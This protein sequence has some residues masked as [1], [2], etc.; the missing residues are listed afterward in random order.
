MILFTLK[1]LNPLF[2]VRNILKIVLVRERIEETYNIQ[3]SNGWSF[4][5]TPLI[6]WHVVIRPQLRTSHM[7]V[8]VKRV[9]VK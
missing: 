9:S 5:S 8:C 2:A 6:R 7:Y 3:M 1:F 4:T